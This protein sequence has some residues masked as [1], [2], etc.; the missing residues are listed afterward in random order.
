M[1]RNAEN[2]KTIFIGQKALRDVDRGAV[3]RDRGDGRPGGV[4]LETAVAGVKNLAGNLQRR[5]DLEKTIAGDRQIQV[6]LGG[7]DLALLVDGLKILDPDATEASFLFSERLAGNAPGG[8]ADIVAQHR[9][10]TGFYSFIAAR[11]DIGDIGGDGA[12]RV[13]LTNH[14]KDAGLK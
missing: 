14:T 4:D 9:R 3:I 11:T 12:E 7:V 1:G 2:E 10:E 8:G 13:R 5:A 6:A